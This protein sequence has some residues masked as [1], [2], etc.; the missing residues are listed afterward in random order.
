MVRSALTFGFPRDVSLCQPAWPVPEPTV[1]QLYVSIAFPAVVCQNSL[2]SQG[3][4]WLGAS[5]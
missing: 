3:R 2:P 5:T 4:R 1:S